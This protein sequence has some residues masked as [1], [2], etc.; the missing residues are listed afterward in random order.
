MIQKAFEI[1][2]FFDEM[3]K[4]RDKISKETRFMENFIQGELWSEYKNA[5]KNVDLVF[6]IVK[7][8]D[9]LEARNALASRAGKQALGGI[10]FSFLCMPPHLIGKMGNIFPLAIFHERYMKEYGT[11]AVFGKCIEDVNIVSK[12]GVLINVK[13]K[14]KRAYFPCVLLS[15]DNTAMNDMCGFSASFTATYY[16]RI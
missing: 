14:Q 8:F 10:Y 16:S 11:V 1:P 12:K 9:G 2:G 4:H 15:G 3:I 7:Y 13:G 5:Y 6:P